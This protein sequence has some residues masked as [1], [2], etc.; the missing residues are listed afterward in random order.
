MKLNEVDRSGKEVIML[1]TKDFPGGTG[2]DHEEASLTYARFETVKPGIPPDTQ[3]LLPR[4]L[5]CL[6]WLLY[7]V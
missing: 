6:Y 3:D 1:L 7:P 5:R 4:N 2:K